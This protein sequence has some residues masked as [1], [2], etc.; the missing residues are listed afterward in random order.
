[1][2]TMLDSPT[3]KSGVAWGN[4]LIRPQR[5]GVI[6]AGGDGVRLRPLTRVISGDE[7]PKQF[8]PILG[9]ETLLEQTRRRLARAVSR[10]RALVVVTRTH[11]RFYAGDVA[12]M[13]SRNLVVQPANRGTAPAIL[14]SLLRIAQ[15]A[16]NDLVAI[17]PSDHFV[18]DDE[19]F[20]AHIEAAFEAVTISPELVILL[21]VTPNNAEVEYGWI[22]PSDPLL[23][24]DSSSFYRV[25]RFWEKPPAALAHTLRAAGCLWNSFV[26]VARVTALVNLIDDA[27]PEL[28]DRF[29][30]FRL[31]SDSALE[32]EAARSVYARIP[33]IDFSSQVL[34]A[35]P[36]SLAVLPV[37]GVAWNDLGNPGRVLATLR[38]RNGRMHTDVRGRTAAELSV[39]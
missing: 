36:A 30:S 3:R 23:S 32:A 2:L 24:V 7:R 19:L 34:A 21:G 18:S 5:W 15:T 28:L 9:R 20:M 11:E 4:G 29:S 35:R 25:R 8:C 6:L 16:T 12:T 27:V 37:S 1:M 39:C 38:Q 33:P 14:Y 22:E 13:D 17:L 31:R 10:H 26:I